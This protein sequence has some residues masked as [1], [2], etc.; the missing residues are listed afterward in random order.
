MA[1]IDATE[2]PLDYRRE[3]FW[4]GPGAIAFDHLRP[5]EYFAFLRGLYPRLDSAALE[6]H[7][8]GFGLAPFL[9]NRLSE[10]ST[11]TQRKVWLSAALSAGTAV[12][13]LDEPLNA[14]DA[15]SLAHLRTQLARCAADTERA[16]LL[17]SHEAALAA[18]DQRVARLD[19]DAAP[20]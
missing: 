16:W 3:V 5:P 8:Q 15:A 4:C 11:G 13:L 7:L 18:P 20:R 1:G 14:L 12:V 19:L 9:H 17:A 6:S 2:R 10:L